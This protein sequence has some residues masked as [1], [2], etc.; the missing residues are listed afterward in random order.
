MKMYM[1]RVKKCVKGDKK[2]QGGL[3]GWSPTKQQCNAVK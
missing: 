1:H 2:L 3:T